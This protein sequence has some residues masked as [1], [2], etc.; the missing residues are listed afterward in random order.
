MNDTDSAARFYFT[1]EECE[2][3]QDAIQSW[4]FN[5]FTPQDVE[6]QKELAVKTQKMKKL[7]KDIESV[8]GEL[9]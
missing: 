4:L 9:N 1:K 7:Y 6:F 5:D 8:K 3:L 2:L